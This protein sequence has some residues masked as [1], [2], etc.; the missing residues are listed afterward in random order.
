MDTVDV[1]QGVFPL[2]FGVGSST[3]VFLFPEAFTA[4]RLQ[5]VAGRR[6]YLF[7]A[8]DGIR[9]TLSEQGTL[10]G[11]IRCSVVKE[12]DEPRMEF[13]MDEDEWRNTG[14]CIHF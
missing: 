10:N 9:Y 11:K 6:Q 5:D 14:K 8:A 1:D 3:K 13:T 7:K 12:T 4:Q 2:S